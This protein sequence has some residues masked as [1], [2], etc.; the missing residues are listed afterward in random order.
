MINS[1]KI[2]L[3]E[4]PQREFYLTSL[5]VFLL[6]F[7]I[8]LKYSFF[9]SSV[10]FVA[11]L[12]SVI[13]AYYFI[14]MPA[15][16]VALMIIGT[17]LDVKG[18][19]PGT[20]LTVFHVA[21]AFTFIT[22]IFKKLWD[23]ELSIKRTN[24]DT[25]LVS[26][27]LL[28]LF[29]LF[30]T[31]VLDTAFVHFARVLV[32][33]F[34]MY[35]VINSINSKTGLIIIIT[36]LIGSG[37]VLSV[38]ALKNMLAMSS[39]IMQLALGLLKVAG[40]FGVTFD[41]PN[42]FATFL[43]FGIS[44]GFSIFLNWNKMKMIFRISLFF[45]IIVMFAAVLGTY[46]RAAWVSS[47]FVFI[48]IVNFSN[49]KR[50]IFLSFLILFIVLGIVFFQNVFIQSMLMRIKSVSDLSGDPSNLTRIFL[51][52]GGI[53]MLI[54]SHFLGV[55]FRG[56]N[57]LYSRVYKPSEHIFFDVVESHTFPI[58]LLAEL[59]IM[60]GI[61]FGTIIFKYFTFSKKSILSI[62]DTF[63]KSCQIGIHAGMVGLFINYLFSPG[64]LESNLVWIG[65]GLTYAI[66]FK[67]VKEKSRTFE[68]VEL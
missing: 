9:L 53:Q 68:K 23:G 18:R 7:I 59:G 63:L 15:I 66:Y 4:I 61:L 6:Y 25:Y 36:S 24:F 49:Y 55:G 3:Y 45:V 51:I 47:A 27:L 19:I 14:K 31:P 39:S 20:P 42:F 54:D 1:S 57:I 11:L 33:V 28:I 10:L 43:L 22:I 12:L 29:S 62:K 60:G 17:S 52:R 44:I 40:R 16:G 34:I 35:L 2:Q 46:S 5:G 21:V 64:A 37:F 32:L 38:I 65:F 30:Y 8:S 56:F 58:E 50:Q 48:I 41:N 26:F 67:S 13:I